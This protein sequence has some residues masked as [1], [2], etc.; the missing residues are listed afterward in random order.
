[1]AEA[2]II[3]WVKFFETWESQKGIDTDEMVPLFGMRTIGIG[4]MRAMAA[5]IPLLKRLVKDTGVDTLKKEVS[6]RAKPAPRGTK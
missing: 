4:C 2:G 3:N 1:M 5:P 6:G